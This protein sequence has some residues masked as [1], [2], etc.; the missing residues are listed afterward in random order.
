MFGK[1]T[2][3]SASRTAD[4]EFRFHLRALR[5]GG[6]KPSEARSAS[7]GGPLNPGYADS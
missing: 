2:A 3:A 6:L 1:T 5:F 7:V 4:P